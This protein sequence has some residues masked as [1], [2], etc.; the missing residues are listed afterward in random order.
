[1]LQDRLIALPARWR[2]LVAIIGGVFALAVIG[3][4]MYRAATYYMMDV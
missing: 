1:M 3:L 4:H 2:R